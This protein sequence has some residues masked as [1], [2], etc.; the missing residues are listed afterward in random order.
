MEQVLGMNYVDQ[1]YTTFP[2]GVPR[3]IC[4][5][6]D[7]H[8][9]AAKY[10][11]LACMWYDMLKPAITDPFYIACN[12]DS[13]V[14]HLDHSES[15][16]WPVMLVIEL[17]DDCCRDLLDSVLTEVTGLKKYLFHHWMD[18]IT[19]MHALVSNTS[20][21]VHSDCGQFAL[22]HFRVVFHSRTL[23]TYEYTEVNEAS[24]HITISEHFRIAS[25]LKTWAHICSTHSICDLQGMPRK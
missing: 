13:C 6:I 19:A 21:A 17:P 25:T 4:R 14:L 1:Y 11:S 24:P 23:G 15:M 9:S 12:R 22:A 18:S 8:P 7:D 5:S 2:G 20:A 10:H 3:H 16:G